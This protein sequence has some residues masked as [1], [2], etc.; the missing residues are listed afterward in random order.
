MTQ[1]YSSLSAVQFLS[2][3]NFS[4]C[5]DGPKLTSFKSI[6]RK[7]KNLYLDVRLLVTSPYHNPCRLLNKLQLQNF[8]VF[9][10]RPFSV[11][12]HVEH[13]LSVGNQRMFLL[14]QL[15]N[16]GLSRNALHIIFNAIVS[17]VITYALPSFAGQLSKGDKARIDS[18]F[19]KAF[20]RGFCCEIIT[21][22]ELISAA[23]KKLFRQLSNDSHCLHPLLPKQRN[24]KL[25]SLRNRGHN[26]ILPRI[27][28]ALFKNS[29]LNRCLFFY[30]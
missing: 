7:P 13:I 24:N 27:E 16:Q 11:A 12:A 18:L 20:R 17:S 19:R 4:M 6:F 10:F 3:K 22:D 8:L 26:Y 9:L 15:K 29:F 14:A 28:T 5:S 2:R 21:I 1:L 23:D 30:V 25:H